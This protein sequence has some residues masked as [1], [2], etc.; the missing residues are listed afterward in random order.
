MIKTLLLSLASFAGT[1]IDDLLVN[2]V[3]FSE[4]SGKK[5][6]RMLVAGKY[7]GMGLLLLASCL[8]AA[9][10][11]LLDQRWLGLLARLPLLEKLLDRYKEVIVPAVYI[12]LG[13][14]ILL[15]SRG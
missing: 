14:Y 4:A 11:R 3:L 5:E 9:G 8:G 6:V 1:N 15:K 7:L 2:T 13:L 10:L 12:L